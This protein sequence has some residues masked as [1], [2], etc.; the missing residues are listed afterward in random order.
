METYKNDA[1]ADWQSFKREFD[2]D[3]DEVGQALKDLRVDN[4]Q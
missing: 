4:E 1:N 2:H 3:I